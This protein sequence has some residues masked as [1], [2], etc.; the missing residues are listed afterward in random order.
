MKYVDPAAKYQEPTLWESIVSWLFHRWPLLSGC[1]AIATSQISRIL[2][3]SANRAIWARVGEAKCLVPLNDLVG[4]SVFLVG[5]LDRKVSWILKRTINCGDTVLDVGANLGLLSL[6][7]A[8]MVGSKGRVISFEP[9][10]VVLQYLRSTL[11][12]NPNLPIELFECALGE[13]EN[14]LTLTVPENNAGQA[15]LVENISKGESF[16]V[17]VKNLAKILKDQ[18]IEKIDVMK[19]DVEGFEMQVLR[20]LFD[21]KNSPRPKVILIEENNP[22]NSPVFEL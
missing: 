9:S 20:G 17:Q 11:S 12:N 13:H 14:T 16:K 6:Q 19:I 22:S 1:G 8:Q 4:R 10:P 18:G 21:E 3:P 15:S 5:D 2:V 7:M